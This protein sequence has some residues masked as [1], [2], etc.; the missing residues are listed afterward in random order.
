[1]NSQF[2]PHSGENLNQQA[3]DRLLKEAA[4]ERLAKHAAAKRNSRWTRSKAPIFT[5]SPRPSLLQPTVSA[6]LAAV[7]A[8]EIAILVAL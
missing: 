6:F 8:L 5:G 2:H 7:I 1:M 3:R 4:R